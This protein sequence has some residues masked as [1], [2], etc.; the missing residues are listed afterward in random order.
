MINGIGSLK[1]AK[2]VHGQ[3]VPNNCLVMEIKSVSS[4]LTVPFPGTFDDEYAVVGGYY[5]WPLNRLVLLR[6]LPKSN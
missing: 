2:V 3:P 4:P 1:V 6:S 5:T